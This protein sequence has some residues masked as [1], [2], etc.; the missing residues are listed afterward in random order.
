MA[1]RGLPSWCLLLGFGT[2]VS[3]SG[4]YEGAPSR[5]FLVE[6]T[7]TEPRTNLVPNPGFEEPF[8]EDWTAAWQWRGQGTGMDGTLDRL[9]TRTGQCSVRL[10]RPTDQPTGAYGVL[11]CKSV[12]PL[13]PGQA[14]TFSLFVRSIRPGRTWFGSEADA[15]RRRYLAVGDGWQRVQFTFAADRDD[16][17]FR[18]AVGLESSTTPI[19]IDDVKLEEGKEATPAPT[20]VDPELIPSSA[21]IAEQGD[22]PGQIVWSLFLPKPLL[23]ARLRAGLDGGPALVETPLTLEPGCWRVVVRGQFGGRD[24]SPRRLWLTLGGP[25]APLLASQVRLRFRSSSNARRRLSA[26]RSRTSRIRSAVA[27]VEVAR[28]NSMALDVSLGVLDTFTAAADEEIRVGQIGPALERLAATEAVARGVEGRLSEAQPAGRRSVHVA[29]ER[30]ALADRGTAPRPAFL[31]GYGHFGLV[32]RDVERLAGCGVNLIQVEVGPDRLF[33][34]PETADPAP[35]REMRDL[36]DRA[37]RV[38]VQVD[39]LISPHYHPTWLLERYPHLRVRREGFLQYCLH[40]PEGQ[41]MLRRSVQALLRPLRGHP[42]LHSVCL[43]NE[44][45]S[46]EAP[47]RFATEQWHGWL[48]HRHP[49]IEALNTRWGTQYTDFD[50]IP[51][52]DPFRPSDRDPPTPRWYEFTRFNAEWFASWHEKLARAVHTA[53]PG[54]PVH[55]KLMTWS[56]MHSAE[57]S[58]GI[59]PTLLGQVTDLHGQTAHSPFR[60]GDGEFAVDWQEALAACDLQRSI[61]PVPVFNSENHLVPDRDVRPVPPEHFRSAL[62]QGAIHGQC[63]TT[64]WA[65]ERSS[66]PASTFAGSFADR[67]AATEAV[68]RVCRDLN[69]LAPEVLAFQRAPARVMIL[70]GTATRVWDGDL[71]TECERQL[72]VCLAFAGLKTGLIT[73]RQLEDG[74]LPGAEGPDRPPILVPNIRHLSDAAFSTLSRYPGRIISVGSA[75]MLDRN[76]YDRERSAQIRMDALPYRSGASQWRD[77]LQTLEPLLATWFPQRSVELFEPSGGLPRGVAWLD[78]DYRGSDLVSICNYTSSAAMLGLRWHGQNVEGTDLFTGRRVGSRIEL[79]SLGIAFVRLQ[80]A[81][82]DA[83]PRPLGPLRPLRRPERPGSG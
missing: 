32:R 83:R 33:P 53:I 6:V 4:A 69:R 71:S 50:A 37:A 34:R 54:L 10:V 39:L 29:A 51:L 24:D 8:G 52:P 25:G 28:R 5:P 11:R 19:W 17:P 70:H 41:E 43:S 36:L 66:D 15:R 68:G 22:S 1:A 2:L 38:G 72:Y 65:W 26:L 40:A 13:V 23:G 27:R 44:P 76:E 55:A 61:K 7:R 45:R 64:L 18:P 63:A 75:Q 9:V 60:H 56:F 30:S 42:A 74:R 35:V 58:E 78:T 77:L 47:C 82:P 59:D 12:V 3:R 62:W 21:E 79:P 67:P 48:R 81:G 46:V 57:V 14:Y 73:E 31:L 80:H 16:V 20:G 49:T